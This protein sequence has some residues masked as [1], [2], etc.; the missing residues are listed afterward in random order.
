[1]YF[2]ILRKARKTRDKGI[3]RAE[4]E[5]LLENMT[6]EIAVVVELAFEPMITV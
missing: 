5:L 2:L 1:M 4:F 3:S 6:H